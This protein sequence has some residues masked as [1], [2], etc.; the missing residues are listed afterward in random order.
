MFV[1]S[2]S[3]VDIQK[4]NS[5]RLILESEALLLCRKT[6]TPPNERKTG[7]ADREDGACR[8]YIRAGGNVQGP[9]VSP[10]HLEP[11]G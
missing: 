2:L 9:G 11:D 8:S 1:V 5:L 3:E 4:I 7:A 10:H 6:L